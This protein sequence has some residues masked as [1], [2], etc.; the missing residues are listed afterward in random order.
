MN[1]AT[2]AISAN[3][4]AAWCPCSASDQ[5]SAPNTSTSATRSSVSR[6][7]P[8]PGR[9]AARAGD[10]AVEHVEQPGDQEH[11]GRQGALPVQQQPGRDDVAHQRQHR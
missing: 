6:G 11:D 9:L 4:A 5:N 10:A 3:A 2:S 8:P 7:T 1:E